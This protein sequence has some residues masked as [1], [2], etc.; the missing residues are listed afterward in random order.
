MMMK[1]VAGF[2]AVNDKTFKINLS[3]PWG[4][5]LQALG[6]ISSTVPFMM[7]ERL[8]NTD[9]NT[10]ITEYIGSGPFKLNVDEWVPGS[11]IVFDKF[12]GYVPRK[13][14]PSGAAGGK[15]AKV[16]R[17][18]ADYIPDTV[19]AV[20]AMLNG[21]IDWIEVLPPDMLPLVEGSDQAVAYAYDPVGGSS[22]I[23]LNHLQP[24]FDNKL[25]RQAVMYAVDQAEFHQANMGDRKEL[26]AEC[27]AIFTCGNPLEFDVGAKAMIRKDEEKAKQLL[28]EANYDGTPIVIIHPTDI[29]TNSDFSYVLAEALKRVG[30]KVDD[31]L[32]DWATVASRRASKAPVTEGGWH[33]FVTGWS[34][35]DLM[36]PLTN[37][38][39]TGA[40]GDGWF[41][42]ACSE[43]LQKTLAAYASSTDPAE[44]KKLA[45]HMQEVAWDIVPFVTLGKI[46]QLSAHRTDTKGWLT[47]PVPFFWN[48]EKTAE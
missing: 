9:P 34:G 20:N 40:C 45:E 26:Y 31:Q 15:V 37:V 38:F 22:Q 5:V 2:E 1:K 16:D 35:T 24:P 43:D 8:A 23:V 39:V 6:K 42:W 47:A 4:F 44:Q 36:N 18:E 25:I 48:V 17:V 46:N 19:T 32:T 28:K 41:G 7:P 14:P 29:K 11:K 30:F 13:E 3:E 10:A 33:I 12:D 27:G 21:E